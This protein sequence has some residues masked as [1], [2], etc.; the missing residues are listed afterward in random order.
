MSKKTKTVSKA[1]EPAQGEIAFAA[2]M[3]ETIKKQPAQLTKKQVY[4]IE[5]TERA[6]GVTRRAAL[7][8]LT[9]PGKK[10][11]AEMRKDK[12]LARALA[13]A[14]ESLGDYIDKL[15]GMSCMMKTAYARLMVAL[16]QREDMR[17]LLKQAKVDCKKAA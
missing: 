11:L 16:A 4:Q 5:D 7:M 8:T 13:C 17:E 15:D 6:M 2:K 14:Y 1:K 3:F 10:L 12:E 9:M